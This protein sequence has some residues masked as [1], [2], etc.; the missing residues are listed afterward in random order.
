MIKAII[1]AAGSGTRL[2][3]YT[4]GSPKCML[5]FFGKSL[6]QR[7]VDTL[8]ESGINN[9]TLVKGYMP[10]KIKIPGIKYF[11]NKD[12]MNTNMV[13]TLFSAEKEITGDIL[14]CYGDIL[15]EKKIIE[16]ILKS[17]VDIG[18]TVDDS[19]WEYWKA[20]MENPEKDIESLV[21]DN[22]GKIIELGNPFCTLDKAKL[23]YVG[24]IKFSEEGSQALKEVYHKN[25]KEYFN[26]DKPWLNSKSF[27]KAYMTC[28]L[29]ALINEGYKVDP[30]I[31]QKGWLEFDT[32][33]DYERAIKWKKEGS[34]NRFINL[35]NGP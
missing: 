9:I 27:K 11:I 4:Q 12:Y 2:E 33:E 29:Q 5:E 7:Q 18:V 22:E 17:N 13:E 28:M 23:R 19:Y 8:K 26:L 24:L 20:R 6:I 16:K 14:I 21:L 1:L 32:K 31:I 3:K 15:Y 34:L 30:I 25:K 35:E 10:D